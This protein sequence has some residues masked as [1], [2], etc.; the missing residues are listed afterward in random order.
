MC[1]NINDENIND[2]KLQGSVIWFIGGNTI[3]TTRDT[4]KL[5]RS[6]SEKR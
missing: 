2:E 3:L 4:L 1:E 6:P 5:N